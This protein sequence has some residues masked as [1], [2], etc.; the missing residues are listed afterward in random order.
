MTARV[1]RTRPATKGVL[2]P[3]SEPKVTT[4]RVR[5]SRPT[6]DSWGRTIYVIDW[7]RPLGG[8][9]QLYLMT[10]FLYYCM[11]RSLITDH[12]YDR[13]CKELYEGWHT[14]KHPHKT[15]TDRGHLLAGTGY[16]IRYP[17]VVRNAATYMLDRHTEL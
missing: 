13:L 3:P 12:D 4:A 1:R 6:A 7:N 15:L 9:L 16:A 8:K 14:L 5:R 10:S 11:N 17:L 2:P